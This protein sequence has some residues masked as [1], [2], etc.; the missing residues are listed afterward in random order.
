MRGNIRELCEIVQQCL[1]SIDCVFV[2]GQ[3]QRAAVMTAIF[4]DLTEA[5]L[6]RVERES[7]TWQL[8]SSCQDGNIIYN[9]GHLSIHRK[10][11]G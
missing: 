3:V 8:S 1:S 4:S 5:E 7:V 6:T 9:S 10:H 11:S 2:V